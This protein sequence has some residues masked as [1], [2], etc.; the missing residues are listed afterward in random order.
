MIGL[1]GLKSIINYMEG[2]WGGEAM[3]EGV[4]AYLV[5]H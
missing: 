2:W 5:Q 3:E 4:A 1:R